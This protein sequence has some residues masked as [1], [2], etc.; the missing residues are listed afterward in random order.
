[1]P[2]PAEN[3]IGPWVAVADARSGRIDDANGRKNTVI[4]N[5]DWCA[6]QQR[7]LSEPPAWQFWR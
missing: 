1:M 6:L 3:E 7:K 2:A 4:E 5:V